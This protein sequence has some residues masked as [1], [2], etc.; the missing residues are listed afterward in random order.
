MR[1]DARVTILERTNLRSLPASSVAIPVGLVTLDLSFISVVKVLP[2]VVAVMAPAAQLVVLIK[3][4]F[5]AGKENVA[6]GGIVRD[7]R[8]H[9]AV[10]EA[11]T[12]GAARC[13]LRR[14]GLIESPVKGANAGN[15]EFLAHFMLDGD[16]EGAQTASTAGMLR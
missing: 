16:V 10:I 7:T 14:R 3:P 1:T 15:T 12:A 5:E 2:A 9:A 11:V 8:V 4:Q 6:R 13:G